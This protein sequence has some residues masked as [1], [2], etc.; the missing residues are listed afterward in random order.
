MRSYIFRLCNDYSFRIRQTLSGR[1]TNWSRD[2]FLRCACLQ[3]GGINSRTRT[4]SSSHVSSLVHTRFYSP[5][6]R[7]A[8]LSLRYG[9][10][11]TATRDVSGIIHLPTTPERGLSINILLSAWCDA[12]NSPPPSPFLSYL[13]LEARILFR[14]R[15][16]V[17]NVVKINLQCSGRQREIWRKNT[18]VS[19][20]RGSSSTNCR[21]RN[22]FTSWNTL[23]NRYVVSL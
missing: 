22:S 6:T 18:L 11:I 3:E 12:I 23:F 14:L 21:G 10:S 2:V 5:H 13:C 4:S 9:V 17:M 8:S 20:W 15:H 19:G 7:R 1:R 16:G